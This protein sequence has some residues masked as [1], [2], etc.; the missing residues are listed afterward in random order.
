MQSTRGWPGNQRALPSSPGSSHTE[1]LRPQ[2]P[3]E[4]PA[5]GT[6]PA[7]ALSEQITPEYGNEH[8]M[9]SAGQE[10]VSPWAQ[11]G[12]WHRLVYG[13]CKG[14]VKSHLRLVDEHGHGLWHIV[15]LLSCLSRNVVTPE[16]RKRHPGVC[17]SP[18]ASSALHAWIGSAELLTL[19]NLRMSL[20]Q[21]IAGQ[22]RE[23]CIYFISRLSCSSWDSRLSWALAA[24]W[25][26]AVWS[27][28]L[29]L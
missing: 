29:L 4:Y 26:A 25:A 16:I 3:N 6:Y 7:K 10:F 13:C 11:Q 28:A 19:Q 14:H 2:S 1:E 9:G 27:S 18:K 22:L 21:P 12:G 23:L 17:N 5:A 20:A 15:F 24:G 8:L